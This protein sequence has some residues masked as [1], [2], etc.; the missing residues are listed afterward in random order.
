MLCS[1]LQ[2]HPSAADPHVCVRLVTFFA[3]AMIHP[4]NMLQVLFACFLVVLSPAILIQHSDL[5]HASK[6]TCCFLGHSAVHAIVSLAELQQG[7]ACCLTI[8]VCLMQVLV[9][10]DGRVKEYDSPANLM[11]IPNGAFRAMVEEAGL[12]DNS[13]AQAIQ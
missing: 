5:S 7:L 9:M 6:L 13:P 11:Q 3:I 12:S 2:L 4:H 1:T 10:D 8:P